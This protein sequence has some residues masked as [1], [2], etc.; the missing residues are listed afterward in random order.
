MVGHLASHGVPPHTRLT[1]GTHGALLPYCPCLLI[2]NGHDDSRLHDLR[3][4]R[5]V[6]EVRVASYNLHVLA[7]GVA[8]PPPGRALVHGHQ[9]QPV[10]GILL[11]LWGEQVRPQV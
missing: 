11:Q 9:A 4:R 5:A 7:L 10:L 2:D 3:I 1:P 6:P 8:G